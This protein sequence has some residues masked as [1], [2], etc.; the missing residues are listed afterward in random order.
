MVAAMAL[1]SR[2]PSPL[3]SFSPEQSPLLPRLV[4]SIILSFCF[5]YP[6]NSSSCS[7]M[8]PYTCTKLTLRHLDEELPKEYRGL[9]STYLWEWCP[10][11]GTRGLN[12]TLQPSP[13]TPKP[14]H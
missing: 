14:G 8:V 10:S 2:P 3:A 6:L 1:S 4:C 7:L 5:L 9:C 12:H 11:E 13:Q